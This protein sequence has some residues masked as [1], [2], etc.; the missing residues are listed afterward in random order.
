MISVVAISVVAAS[1]ETSVVA[2]SGVATSARLCYFSTAR[3]RGHAG[4]F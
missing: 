1:G 2:A 3:R 4:A